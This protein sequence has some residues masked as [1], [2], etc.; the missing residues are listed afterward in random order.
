MSQSQYFRN[1]F[2]ANLDEAKSKEMTITEFSFDVIQNMI[3]F[4]YSEALELCDFKQA[5]E[6]IAASDKYNIPVLKERCED[7]A[8]AKLD[9]DNI[10]EA[11][12]MARLYKLKKLWKPQVPC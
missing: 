6:L 11:L 12:D 8:V 7:F 10:G 2:D 5:I 4:L 9:K 1:M 3:G